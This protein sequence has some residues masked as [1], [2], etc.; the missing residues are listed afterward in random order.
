MER[1][2]EAILLCSTDVDKALLAAKI[3]REVGWEDA[4][5]CRGLNRLKDPQCPMP[6]V[7]W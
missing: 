2:K 5:L 7:L 1:G 4:A 6:S 3:G